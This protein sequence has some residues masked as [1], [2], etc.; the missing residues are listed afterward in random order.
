MQINNI[1]KKIDYLEYLEIR[2]EVVMP[3]SSFERLNEE[4]KNTD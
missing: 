4:A 2:G 3:L 1:P